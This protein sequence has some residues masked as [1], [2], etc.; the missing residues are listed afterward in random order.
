M[1]QHVHA[2]L[3]EVKVKFTGAILAANGMTTDTNTLEIT[4]D[5]SQPPSAFIG[6]FFLVQSYFD[7]YKIVQHSVFLSNRAH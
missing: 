7:T 1:A 4:H 6:C 2:E 5:C 3:D